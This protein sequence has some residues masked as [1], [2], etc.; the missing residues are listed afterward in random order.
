VAG[1]SNALLGIAD[2]RAA[3]A[4]HGVAT[5]HDATIQQPFRAVPTTVIQLP[6]ARTPNAAVHVSLYA[7]Y[8]APHDDLAR[9]VTPS[10]AAPAHVFHVRNALL[11]LLADPASDAAIVRAVED[12]VAA[13]GG[14]RTHHER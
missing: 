8:V 3:L 4:A 1:T 13:L 9:S 11:V 2:I 12:A 5:G 6:D 14:M 10:W 7:S